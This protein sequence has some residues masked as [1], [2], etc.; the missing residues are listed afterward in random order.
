MVSRCCLQKIFSLLK[1]SKS[2]S[3]CLLRNVKL[4]I[5]SRHGC[6]LFCL[7][8]SSLWAV[9]YPRVV[10]RKTWWCWLSY[11]LMLCFWSPQMQFHLA[12]LCFGGGTKLK[13]GYLKTYADKTETI[14]MAT[15]D[16]G[17]CFFVIWVNSVSKTSH[18]KAMGDITVSQA[19]SPLLTHLNKDWI[20]P[21]TMR[22]T[23]LD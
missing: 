5:V 18:R 20:S 14:C 8:W 3:W 2:K 17:K 7:I 16:R 23:Y 1:Y 15:S 12:P 10:S 22:L 21:S 9:N 13:D 4:V 19:L 11:F 6:W